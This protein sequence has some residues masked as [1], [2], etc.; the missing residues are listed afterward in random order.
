M[1]EK[2]RK[3]QSL[4]SLKAEHIN[5]KGSETMTH[6]FTFRQLALLLPLLR[7]TFLLLSDSTERQTERLWKDI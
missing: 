5:V 6:L 2:E 1:C 3:C 4:P 7:I